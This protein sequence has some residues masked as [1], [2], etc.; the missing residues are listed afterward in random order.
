MKALI[1]G[2]NGQDGQF[3]GRLLQKKNVEWKGVSR[4]GNQ[5]IGN[6]ADR[7]FVKKVIQEEKPSHI[8]H[9]AANSTT[10]HD[11]IFE[12][13]EAIST[14]TFNILESVR[15]LNPAIKVFLSGSALQLKNDGKPIDENCVADASSA[16]SVSRIQSLYAGRYFRNKFQI[17][18]YFGYFFNHDSELRSERHVNQR[19][20]ATAKRISCGSQEKLELG[21]VGVLKEFNYAGD[22]VQAIWTLVNQDKVF[23]TVL[24]SGKAY[25]IKDWADYCFK[26]IGKSADDYITLKQDFV[27]EYEILVSNPALIKSLGWEPK[28]SFEQLADLMLDKA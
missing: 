10:R 16:Y 21:N 25:S 22:I 24:G 26:K 23:E 20:A 15:E 18:V 8:F 13:H 1:F 17:P 9:F 5:I 14:G 2:S 7:A 19:I 11:A 6:V 28:V 4:S 12:N 27:P 3:L